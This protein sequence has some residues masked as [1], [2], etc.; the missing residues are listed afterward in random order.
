MRERVFNFF[1][2][3]FKWIKPHFVSILV[4]SSA[5]KWINDTQPPPIRI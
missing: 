2:V 3:I 1:F 4:K 5:I